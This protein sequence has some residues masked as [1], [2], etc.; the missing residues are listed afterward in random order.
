MSTP[1]AATAANIGVEDIKE[2]RDGNV[3]DPHGE[4]LGKLEEILY[5]TQSDQPAFGAVKSGLLGKKLTYVPL[6]GAT[7]GKSFIRIT[8]PKDRFK[9]APSYD[10]ELELTI[11][12][13]EEVYRYHG[14][15]Y[16]PAGQDA[17]R[18][19]KH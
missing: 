9:K 13:E 12:D 5:D 2:W 18:L 14:L 16:V 7:V 6:A 1:Q 17:R 3:L 11:T 15:D 8:T 19:A 4:K 10:P